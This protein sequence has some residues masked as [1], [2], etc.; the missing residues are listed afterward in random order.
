MKR[1][2][3]KRGL[4]FAIFAMIGVAGFGLAVL[5]LWNTLMPSI[6]GL[7]TITFWQALGLLALSWILFGRLGM[8][9]FRPA[10]ASHW[11]HRMAER[12]EQMPPDQREKFRQGLK[13]RCGRSEGSTD[14]KV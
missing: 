6:F 14:Q 11:R 12:L 13:D 4:K 7:H 8:S 9:R 10:Y 2:W 5:Q 3:K 1:N